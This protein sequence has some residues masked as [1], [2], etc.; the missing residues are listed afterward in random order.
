MPTKDQRRRIIILGAGPAGLTAAYELSK[1][2]ITS[3]MLEAE[4]FVGGLARTA[5][6]N[7]YLFDIGGHRFY[8]QM[9]LIADTWKEILGEDLLVRKRV[10]RIRYCSRF[11]QYP[12]ELKDV[13]LRLGPIEVT[14]STLSFLKAKIRPI[15]PENDFASWVTNRFGKRLFELFFRTYTEKVWGIKC[16]QI[17][18]D[19]AAQRIGRLSVGAILLSFLPAALRPRSAHPVKTLIHEFHYPRRG[20]GMMWNKVKEL[21]E[22]SGSTVVTNAPADRVYWCG[23]RVTAVRAGGRMYEGTHF[24]SSVAIR[25]LIKSL[26]PRAPSEVVSAANSLQ[27]RDFLTVALVVEGRNLFP[28]NWLYI[29]DPSVKVGRIQNYTN[30]SEE[31][32][33]NASTSCLGFEYFCFE[34]DGLWSSPNKDLIALASRELEKLGLAKSRRVLDGAVV[35]VKKAYPVYNNTYK[36]SLETIRQFVARIENL[37]LIGRNGTHRYN[38]Q[39]HSM[40]MGILAARN[41]VGANYNLW[42]MGADDGYLESAADITEDE[43]RNLNR[44]QPQ[45]P[46]FV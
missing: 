14:R 16:E 26:E 11:F 22:R 17:S 6:H 45:V 31:M 13:L 43:I 20:P 8:T 19:W 12:L 33:P 21:V 32:S 34:N 27:Y 23:D 9:R 29:H 46:R 42:E 41:I 35:R 28:D 15:H 38:N 10:S 36:Q 25:D 3:T 40:M 44:T 7:G 5:E 39:D 24:V 30:W 2:G 1:S 4:S 37:Q 18:S